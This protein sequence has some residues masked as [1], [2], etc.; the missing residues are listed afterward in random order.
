MDCSAGAPDTSK[1]KRRGPREGAACGGKIRE[2]LLRR[3][4]IGVRRPVRVLRHAAR[5]ASFPPPHP[6]Q[7][8]CISKAAGRRPTA[9]AP[10]LGEAEPHRAASPAPHQT[11]RRGWRRGG[12]CRPRCRPS[13]SVAKRSLPPLGRL[14][15]HR[16]FET[17]V[18]ELAMASGSLSGFKFER[19]V[20][21]VAGT[22]IRP[23]NIERGGRPAATNRDRP[24]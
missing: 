5:P 19:T 4:S 10:P 11:H 1:V 22:R 16:H 15:E 7:Y 23:L 14:A 13:P 24:A 17:T 9:V 18:Y 2:Q 20:L 8:S 21:D 6:T 12:E 3:Q